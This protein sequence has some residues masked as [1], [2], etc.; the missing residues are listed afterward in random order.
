MP[1]RKKKSLVGWTKMGFNLKYGANHSLSVVD[2]PKIYK[3]KDSYF[4]HES[5]SIYVDSHIKVRITIE[6]QP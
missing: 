3:T 1:R 5:K 4:F 6:E 2:S